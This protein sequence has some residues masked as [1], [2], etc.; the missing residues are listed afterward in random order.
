MGKQVA[1]SDLGCLDSAWACSNAM[2]SRN[3]NIL[4]ISYYYLIILITDTGIK[5]IQCTN[6]EPKRWQAWAAFIWVFG[7]HCIHT[8][9]WLATHRTNHYS[10]CV[11]KWKRFAKITQFILL[12]DGMLD[13]TFKELHGNFEALASFDNQ[14]Q[15]MNWKKWPFYFSLSLP[16]SLSLHS[17][18]SHYAS[19][20]DPYTNEQ[21]HDFSAKEHF[22]S[23]AA[24]RFCILGHRSVWFF[25]TV[26][27]IFNKNLLR[28]L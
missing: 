14:K 20:N 24:C 22:K 15:R 18:H 1:K 11:W 4:D 5:Y 9:P 12:V 17:R 23:M 2:P 16:L 26:W 28:K 19:L 13:S 8:V 7:K 10:Q 27:S 6:S 21:S 25:L 3:H